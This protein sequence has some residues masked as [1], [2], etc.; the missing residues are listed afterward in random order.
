MMS[1]ESDAR[2]GVKIASVAPK[3]PNRALPRIQALYLLMDS[4]T[5][6]PLAFFD[7]T[8]LTTLRTAAVS[9][10][11]CENTTKCAGTL[12]IRIKCRT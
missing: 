11:S 6:T 3:H 5:L 2:P 10:N 4:E 12:N 9:D 1:A 8:A 7:G